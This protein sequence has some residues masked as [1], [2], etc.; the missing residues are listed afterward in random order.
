M[1][2]LFSFQIDFYLYNVFILLALNYDQVRGD[3]IHSLPRSWC[4]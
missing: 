3:F 4:M 1:K 2:I